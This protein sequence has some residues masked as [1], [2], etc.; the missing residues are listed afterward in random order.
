MARTSSRSGDVAGRDGGLSAGDAGG[1]SSDSTPQDDRGNGERGFRDARLTDGFERTDGAA[2]KVQEHGAF[3]LD[4]RTQPAQASPKSIDARAE[5]ARASSERIL[6]QIERITDQRNVGR[7]MVIATERGPVRVRIE[8]TD[9]QVNVNFR[10]EDDQ[11]KNM[12]RS[13]LP[14]LQASLERRGFAQNSFRFDGDASSD[15]M[16]GSGSGK[17]LEA[18]AAR[19]SL[20]GEAMIETHVAANVETKKIDPRSLLSVVA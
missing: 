2:A 6:Q 18:R 5:Q 4:T 20:L 8:V 19:D 7:D 13:G 10:A 12:L 16:A 3:G 14:A 11:L 17:H 15:L 1:R 9:K